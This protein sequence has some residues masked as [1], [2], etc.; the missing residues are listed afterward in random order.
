MLSVGVGVGVDDGSG[1]GADVCGRYFL[2][3]EQDGKPFDREHRA[4]AYQRAKDS[5]DLLPFGT[6]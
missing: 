3:G 6:R 1:V 2:E 4:I 5:S